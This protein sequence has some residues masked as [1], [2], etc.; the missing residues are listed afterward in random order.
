MKLSTN[1]FIRPLSSSF[2]VFSLIFPTSSAYATVLS[3]KSITPCETSCQTSSQTAIPSPLKKPK[4]VTPLGCERPF[5][6]REETYSADPPQS[7]DASTLKFFV[8]SVPEANKILEEYQTNLVK[9]K[10]SAYIGTMGVLMVFFA[11]TISNQFN[12]NSRVPVGTAL[13]VGGATFALGGFFFTFAHLRDNEYLIPKAV[14][15]Y[16]RSK[17]NDPIE[18]QFT[19]GWNF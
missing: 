1:R 9:S 12:A 13:R 4:K 8:Q 16:N 15:S 7:K 3:N 6:Y 19:T 18:L 10:T 14:E 2:L 17:P 5:T 11:S